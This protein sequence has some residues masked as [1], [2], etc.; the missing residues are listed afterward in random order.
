[1]AEMLFE[2]L[3]FFFLLEKEKGGKGG[4]LGGAFFLYI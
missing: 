3:I 2:G 1:M 4:W